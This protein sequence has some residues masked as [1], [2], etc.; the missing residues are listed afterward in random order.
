MAAWR[1]H[2]YLRFS[3]A[4]SGSDSM[5][6]EIAAEHGALRRRSSPRWRLRSLFA[7]VGICA[8]LL[9]LLGQLMASHL[10]DSRATSCLESQG[11]EV[12]G[13][14]VPKWLIPIVRITGWQP[15]LAAREVRLIL[16]RS[17][18]APSNI[19]ETIRVLS[20]FS[21]I[22]SLIVSGD[23]VSNDLIDRLLRSHLNVGQLVVNGKDVESAAFVHLSDSIVQSLSIENTR[24]DA[25]IFR[26]LSGCRQLKRFGSNGNSLLS[27]LDRLELCV[28]SELIH[29]NEPG[30]SNQEW[31]RI[32]VSPRLKKLVIVG[33]NLSPNT[34][35]L[36][37]RR[38]EPTTVV[39]K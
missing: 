14:S 32:K 10:S 30:L 20:A 9:W 11:V 39:F 29:L 2:S 19:D 31:L 33:C 36:V 28:A 17:K 15:P 18:P 1:G 38:C 21:E 22:P 23:M 3:L 12:R 16:D 27:G 13:K 7:L 37:R 6:S 25:E 24:V 8:V 34:Q 26:H 5:N 4:R 35:E